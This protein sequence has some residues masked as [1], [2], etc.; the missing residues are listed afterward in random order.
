MSPLE[1]LQPPVAARQPV[2]T[3][4]HGHILQDDYAWMRDK[5]SPQLLAPSPR[6]ER[7]YR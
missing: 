1:S 2:L 3:E 5:T 6:R 7:V 4:L